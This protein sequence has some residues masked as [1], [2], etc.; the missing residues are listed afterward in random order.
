MRK[1]KQEH[2]NVVR[3]LSKGV[4][5]TG[6]G[7]K[8]CTYKNGYNAT[9]G[10]TRDQ[11]VFPTDLERLRKKQKLD[12]RATHQFVAFKSHDRYSFDGCPGIMASKAKIRRAPETYM[13][14]VE[15]NAIQKKDLFF[16]NSTKKGKPQL[17]HWRYHSKY[18]SVKALASADAFM[19]SM[20]AASTTGATSIS[21]LNKRRRQMIK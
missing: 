11:S 19:E 14:C 9:F 20:T 21:P 12:L 2:P 3:D 8:V 7:R 6:P 1:Q 16:C 5:N 4:F 17:C 10:N 13:Q 15:C 18:C